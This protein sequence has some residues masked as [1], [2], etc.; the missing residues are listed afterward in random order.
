[1]TASAPSTTEIPVT[2]KVRYYF[3]Y[4]PLA[5]GLFLFQLLPWN[6]ATTLGQSLGRLFS[7]I[8]RKRYRVTIDNLT[9][10]FPEKNPA[11][12]E[13]IARASWANIGRIA[14]EFIKVTSSSPEDLLR[15]CRIENDAEF[16]KRLATGKGALVHVAHFTN[17]EVAGL[18]LMASGYNVVALARITRNPYVE[19]MMRKR[20][21]RFGGELVGHRNPFFACVKALKRGKAICIAMDQNMP[22][23]ELFLPFFGRICSV[24]PVTALLSLKTNTPIYPLH[25]LRGPDGV[26]TAR[27]EPAIIPPEH[28]TEEGV[29]DMVKLLN[30]RLENWIRAN[31]D[32]WLWSHNRWKRENDPKRFAQQENKL[33]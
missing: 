27:F 6:A 14:A 33:G 21:L 26:I 7:H 15:R 23:G 12:I 17:W 9:K 18:A 5:A 1:M 2:R 29:L 28:Y 19:T 4:L 3:E 30:G 24:S 22:A 13:A 20:R 8:V 11:E 32:M 10:A 25:V 31:P 16:R